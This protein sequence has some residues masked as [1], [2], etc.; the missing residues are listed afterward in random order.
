MTMGF[1][2]E[3][4][5]CVPSAA[6]NYVHSYFTLFLIILVKTDTGCRRI[7]WY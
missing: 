6:R 5:F 2:A 1:V 4:S 3:F 7:Y